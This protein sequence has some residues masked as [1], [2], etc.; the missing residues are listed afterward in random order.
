MTNLIAVN[1]QTVSELTTYLNV[2]WSSPL[3][4]IIAIYLL[5][6]YLGVA[7]LIGV[8][9]M[10]IFIP[11][12]L[13]LANRVKKLQTSKL[14]IQDSRIKMMNEILSGMKVIKFYGWEISFQNIVQQIRKE[15]L[16]FFKRIGLYNVAT[17]FTWTCAPL[18]VSIVSFAA[19]VLLDDNN[20]LDASTAFVSLSLFNILRFPMT[21]LPGIISAL[22]N[23]N[24]SLKRIRDFL[25]KDEIDLSG[26]TN[27]QISGTSI[28]IKDV[29]FGFDNSTAAYLKNINIE[30]KQGE[31]IA[32]VGEVGCGK[33]SLLSGILG[34]MYKLNDG[35]FNLNGSTAYVPQQAWIQNATVK[36]NILFGREYDE[37]IYNEIIQASCL[38]TDLNIMPAGDLTEIGEKGINLSGG[39][40]QRISLARSLYSN[41]DIYFF[42]DPLSAVDSHVGKDLF[43]HVIGPYGLLKD[44]TRIFVTNSLS[45]LPK[46]DRIIMMVNGMIMEV[47]SYEQLLTNNEGKFSEFIKL[48][49]N[50]K[51][52]NDEHNK[53]EDEN[54]T[55]K[56]EAIEITS[57]P[58]KTIV[59]GE[60]I[61]VKEKIESGKVKTA[62]FTTYFKACGYVFSIMAVCL[63]G[64]SSL[65]QASSNIWLSH[66]SNENKDNNY[67]MDEK[68]QNKYNGLLVFALLGAV[69]C[70]IA[71][72]KLS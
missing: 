38:A 45:F 63:F 70:V 42:D 48:Y 33:S 17:S 23:A 68:E 1:A 69:Q 9:T 49:L 61:I 50:N 67:S 51:I 6:Q 56:K 4:I 26:T 43:D 15:E 47:G 32:V 35:T 20:V 53:L 64:L 71:L 72:C 5:V 22:I 40:K 60:K 34:E 28:L 16:D 2:L 3:Q 37:K 10:V 30:I 25:L 31:L 24:V 13:V 54:T 39:Q 57:V 66:W 27:K 55:K 65:A 14:K 11:I 36:E 41:C 18:I 58:S 21:V 44:K 59:A 52:S 29:D 12:N 46:V 19:F 8:V 7:A 62:V